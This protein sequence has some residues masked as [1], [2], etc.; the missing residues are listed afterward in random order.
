MT[1]QVLQQTGTERER[2]RDEEGESSSPCAAVWQ[3]LHLKG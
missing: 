1:K 3:V 2:E